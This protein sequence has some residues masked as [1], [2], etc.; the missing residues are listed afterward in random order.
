MISCESVINIVGAGGI[1]CVVSWA[2]LAAGKPIRVFESNSCRR[3]WIRR[4]GIHLQGWGIQR[5]LVDEL[6]PEAGEL[7]GPT[8]VCIKTYD[9]HSVL[10]Y[11]RKTVPL[12]VIQ[13]GMDPVWDRLPDRTCGIATFIGEA[14][15]GT[16]NV[17][18]TRS[19]RLLLGAENDAT[20]SE[21]KYWKNLLQYPLK[22]VGIQTQGICGISPYRNMKFVYNCAIS[23][24]ASSLGIDNGKL[25]SDPRVRRVFLELLKENIRIF[26]N[27]KLPLGKVGPFSPASVVSILSNKWLTTVLAAWFERSLRGTYCSMSKDFLLGKTEFDQY[28]G[29]LIRLANGESCPVNEL[30]LREVEVLLSR[31]LGPDPK[32]IDRLLAKMNESL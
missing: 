3:D 13:N 25:L 9:N 32:L 12:L 15:K 29:R 20:S 17:N 8:I 22:R 7:K 26:K 10:S 2:L 19:G 31:G 28:I 16:T 18:L 30:L 1:G 6:S 23:P 24:L 4:Y 14:I 27:Q 11:I 5:P 21:T